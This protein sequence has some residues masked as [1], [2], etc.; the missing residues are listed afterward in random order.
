M[1]K[2]ALISYKGGP[3]R[4]QQEGK[5]TNQNMCLIKILAAVT[6]TMHKARKYETNM[7]NNFL[8]MMIFN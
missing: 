8:I 1:V 5:M 2:M 6:C 4:E 3:C 7:N